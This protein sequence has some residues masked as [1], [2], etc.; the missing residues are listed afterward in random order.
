VPR[1][2]E[3]RPPAEPS[4]A[5]QKARYRRILRAAAR[6]GAHE[7]LDR[8]QMQDVAREADVAIATLYRYFPSKVHLFAAV[9]RSQVLRLRD[10]AVGPAP[11]QDAVA[12]VAELLIGIGR[13]MLEQPQLS[14]SMIQA[15]NLA[16]KMPGSGSDQIDATFEEL[17]MRTAGIADD[18]TP[19]DHRR[20]RLVILCWFGVLMTVLNGRHDAT[21]AE[22]DT[23][24][25]CELLLG[26]EVSPGGR[27]P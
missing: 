13:E 20:A 8:V 10:E 18:P 16:Q 5:G 11:G 26:S 19:D 24:R 6:L 14:L 7:E 23:R 27:H 12:A 21:T 22:A 25:A 9:M 4:S 2:G 17:V 15:N 3:I 1:V